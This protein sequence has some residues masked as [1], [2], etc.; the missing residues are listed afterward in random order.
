[1]QSQAEDRLLY[2]YKN[3]EAYLVSQEEDAELREAEP[4][5]WA[6]KVR[7]LLVRFLSTELV[8]HIF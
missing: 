7:C 3:C 2:Y 8:L 6:E 1:M 5:A 4:N